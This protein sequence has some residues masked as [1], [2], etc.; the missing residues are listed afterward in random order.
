[1]DPSIAYLANGRLFLK[2]AGKEPREVESKF[3]NQV[4]ARSQKNSERNA[5]K[6]QGVWG[7]GGMGTPDFGQFQ[8]QV[9]VGP[10]I[11]F[12]HV[13]RGTEVGEIHY[14]LKMDQV[15]GV[16]RYVIDEDREIRVLH[17]DN[18]WLE[19]LDR[20]PQEDLYAMSIQ[21]ETGT[22]R[23]STSEGQIR[24]V[25]SVSG[26]FTKD[27]M[28]SWARDDS[29]RLFYQ[30]AQIGKDEN[31][32]PIGMGPYAIELL[33]VDAGKVST[34]REDEQYD[35]LAP[36]VDQN[37]WLY[38]I[39]R[40]WKIDQPARLSPL[41]FLK[42]VVLFPYRVFRTIVYFFNFTSVM[43]SG[44][45]L[46]NSLDFNV[47][48]ADRQQ[49]FLSLWGRALDT[50][51]AINRKTNKFVRP[52]VP[53]DWELC[54]ESLADAANEE[55]ADDEAVSSNKRET[56]AGNAMSFDIGVDGKVVYSDGTRIYH[57]D[58]DKPV[59]LVAGSLIQSVTVIDI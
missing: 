14:V 33:D 57:L 56:L 43:F 35:F 34:I 3:G 10:N 20:H 11:R 44:R 24:P 15:V 2:L 58:G 39:R 52:L 26:G 23:I 13:C 28:P 31:G 6:S 8:Q 38:Y 12:E 9:A 19:A 53:A 59:E 16:F 47:K 40:P 7:S 37:G 50:N 42:D 55:V 22:V 18:F 1:M 4:I 51:K 5:W 32:Y 27:Q 41:E 25:N 45:P 21:Q 49:Q 30:S 17:R 29:K 46:A 54:R 48:P 36:K